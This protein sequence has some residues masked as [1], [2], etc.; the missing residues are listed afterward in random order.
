MET[1]SALLTLC[2]GIHPHKGHWRGSLMFSLIF[3]WTNGRVNN[4]DVGDLRRHRAHHY[5]TLMTLAMIISRNSTE[6][7]VFFILHSQHH[8][9]LNSIV[10]GKTYWGLKAFTFNTVLFNNDIILSHHFFRWYHLSSSYVGMTLN[11]FWTNNMMSR[12]HFHQLFSFVLQIGLEDHRKWA[13][14]PGIWRI[15][16]N[17]DWYSDK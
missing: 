17:C 10:L 1:F 6:S 11:E 8:N 14:N 16:I 7:R 2:A 5:V 4:R 13:E 3:A 9:D 12:T 15:K